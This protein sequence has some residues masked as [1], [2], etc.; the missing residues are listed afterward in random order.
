[1]QPNV[2][3][4]TA[5]QPGGTASGSGTTIAIGTGSILY[6]GQNVTVIKDRLV[7]VTVGTLQYLGQ[8]V[9]VFRN[10]TIAVTNGTLVY[11]GQAIAIMQG[12]AGV[13]SQL[14]KRLGLFLGLGL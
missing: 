5:F 12:G 7:T 10:R 3:Q 2:F 9:T 11:G 13:V 4:P 14:F 6:N 1:M 8:A